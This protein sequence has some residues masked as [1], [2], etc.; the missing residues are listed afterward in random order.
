MIA[1]KD[2]KL[3]D[4]S[5]Q[6]QISSCSS[7]GSCLGG[8][9]S[10][11]NFLVQFG[12][13]LETQDPYQGRNSS[14]KFSAEEIN[15]GFQYKLES[16]PYVGNSLQYSRYFAVHPEKSDAHRGRS[17]VIK[18]MM[19]KY[20]SPAVVTIAAIS[21]NGGTI[22][23]C[24]SVNSQGNHMQSIVGWG[25]TGNSNHVTAIN[26]WGT[27]HGNNGFTRMVWECGGGLNRGIGRYAR[28]YEYKSCEI[29]VVAN[30]GGDQ[31]FYRLTPKHGVWIGE[32]P[33][34]KSDQTCK[35]TPTEG[36][37]DFDA[38]GCRAFAS[39]EISTE[40]HLTAHSE[41]CGETKSS[42]ALVT[43]VNPEDNSIS[44]E[45]LTPH[46]RIPAKGFIK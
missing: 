24:S 44:S 40:Y 37:S 33:V 4:L 35:I 9:I 32:K 2:S 11:P 18:A 39:P 26:S 19:V 29:P 25:E 17:E 30:L 1:A 31:R 12:N 13:P 16:A 22:T 10:A 15:K 46:G 28:V 41:S 45:I 7:H 43:P 6:T 3:V 38:S 42:M 8:Y 21:S 20:R 14:C 23:S 34:P 5:V 27:G 36:L